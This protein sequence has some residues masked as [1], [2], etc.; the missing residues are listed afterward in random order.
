MEYG[1]RRNRPCL[2]A[3]SHLHFSSSQTL[4]ALPCPAMF[5][6]SSLPRGFWGRW[7]TGLWSVSW[8]WEEITRHSFLWRD[9]WIEQVWQSITHFFTHS[10]HRRTWLSKWEGMGGLKTWQNHLFK[11]EVSEHQDITPVWFPPS[12]GH[13]RCA[14]C[15]VSQV[16]LSHQSRLFTKY[17]CIQGWTQ[18]VILSLFI[19]PC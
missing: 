4:P 18:T 3:Q 19:F 12:Y 10:C 16:L 7:V 17:S 9:Q 15:Q 8:W 2:P 14:Y 11:L 1:L 6:W 13:F 5:P